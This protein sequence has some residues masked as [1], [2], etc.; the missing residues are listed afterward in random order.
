MVAEPHAR[1]ITYHF[2]HA[3][4]PHLELLSRHLPLWARL[5]SLLIWWPIWSVTEEPNYNGYLAS[6]FAALSRHRWVAYSLA[7]FCW[8]LQHSFLPFT[9]EWR[10]LLYKL[11]CAHPHRDLPA[12]AQTCTT[13]SRSLDDGHCGRTVHLFPLKS[14]NSRTTRK[15][16]PRSTFARAISRFTS[17]AGEMPP[18]SDVKPSLLN[19]PLRI[20]RQNCALL[21]L[22]GALRLQLSFLS[23][24]HRLFQELLSLRC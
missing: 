21:G 24:S 17:F 13:D 23:R 3:P 22:S 2:W 20:N 11:L 15:L 18:E 5:Y 9:F 6:R 12:H 19:H 14:A 4:I 16:P 7:G 1:R 10:S 8:A